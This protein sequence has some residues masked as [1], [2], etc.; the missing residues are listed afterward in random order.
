MISYS[1]QKA[2]EHQWTFVA[3]HGAED[4]YRCEYCGE[5]L[6]QYVDGCRG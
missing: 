1:C 5:E 4:L 6:I 3:S 2:E